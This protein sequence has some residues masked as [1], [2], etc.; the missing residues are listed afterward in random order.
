MNSSLTLSQKADIALVCDIEVS[1]RFY[2]LLILGYFYSLL[3]SD[4]RSSLLPSGRL[5]YFGRK[6]DITINIGMN[7]FVL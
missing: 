6:I 2:C 4:S 1:L 5:V 3:D 7:R